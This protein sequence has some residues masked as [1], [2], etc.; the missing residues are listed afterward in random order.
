MK[1]RMPASTK[2]P[3]MVRPDSRIEIG[4]PVA[5]GATVSTASLKSDKR[6][7]DRCWCPWERPGRGRC[8]PARS[9]PPASSA[10]MVA[11]VTRLRR[12]R[13]RQLPQ[14]GLEARHDRL[15]GAGAIVGGPVRQRVQGVGQGAGVG[16]GRDRSRRR[17][18][19]RSLA[20]VALKLA[21][22]SRVAGR[23]LHVKGIEGGI[24]QAVG[25]GDQRQFLVLIVRHEAGKRQRLG[26][27]AAARTG[28]P[29]AHRRRPAKAPVTLMVLGEVCGIAHQIE[30]GGNR[31]HFRAAQIQRIGIETQE[32]RQ[33]QADHAAAAPRCAAR[34]CDGA[35]R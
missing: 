22:I 26:D 17:P 29:P 1:D 32:E 31:F 3:T 5:S 10:G 4:A 27:A 16:C 25:V 9:I 35:R 21:T 2:A 33:H 34:S 7:R 20:A 28:A 24:Q 19:A 6:A 14:H 23:R 15:G 12:Q 11:S 30:Q 18:P 13:I 8:R